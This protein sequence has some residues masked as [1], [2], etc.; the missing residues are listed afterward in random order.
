MKFRIA[1]AALSL[2]AAAGAHAQAY[3]SKNVSLVVPAAPGGPSDAIARVLSEKLKAAFGQNVVV[4]NRGGANGTI[5]V[6]SVVR[7]PADGHMVLFAVDGPVTTI[8]ALMPALPYD[9]A[10]D[11][12]PV[13]VIGDGGD[14]VLAVPADSPVKDAKELADAM[15]KAP[16]AANY[17]SSGAGFTSHIVG[18]LYKREG[19][20][21][22]QHVPVRG[23]G[24]AMAELLSGRYSFSFPPASVAAAHARAGKIRVLATAA[25]K[26]NPL[27]SDTPT[28]AEAVFPGVTPP[29][30]WIATYVPAATP[31]ATVER[32]AAATREATRSDD[33]AQLLK[34]QGLVPSAATPAQIQARVRSETDYWKK[35]VQQL[36]IKME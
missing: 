35:T 2:A 17:V 11:L 10:R 4:E 19:R 16:D 25:A 1:L 18:E 20:F 7:A 34:V 3:P 13:A 30:Y 28:L 36:D 26:R 29:S 23:A 33:F 31:A 24:A 8:P 14:V 5:G 15:R 27:F 9:A 6:G 32:L 22:A 12:M 21:S